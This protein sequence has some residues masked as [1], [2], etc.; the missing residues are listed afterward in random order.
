M[1]TKK[2][3]I[4]FMA[5]TLMAGSMAFGGTTQVWLFS[6]DDTTP[7]PDVVSN[8]YGNPELVVKPFA[9]WIPFIDGR[10]GVWPLSGKI[11]AYIPNR[12]EI[13]WWKDIVIQLTWKPAGLTDAFWDDKPNVGVVPG[14]DPYTLYMEST[15]TAL[16]DGWMSSL[17]EI[18]L[19]PNPP[20]ETIGIEGDI[21]VDQ[22]A[23]NTECIPE[24]ATICLLG[25][26]ALALLRKRRV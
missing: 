23:I 1:M 11:D 2:L 17:Y 22:L 13:C 12:P 25:L 24:P 10:D 9:P 8:P 5:V 14:V 3:T 6:N 21:L 7:A 16:G 20:W 15:T 18:R 4:V 19:F 26:G